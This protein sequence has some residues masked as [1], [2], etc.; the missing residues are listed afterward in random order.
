LD[1]SAPLLFFDLFNS[2]RSNLALGGLTDDFS[3][4]L[5]L[6]AE[7]LNTLIGFLL[8]EFISELSSLRPSLFT[9]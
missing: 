3:L 4:S 1:S 6:V 7:A 8:I 9:W 5:S 2:F